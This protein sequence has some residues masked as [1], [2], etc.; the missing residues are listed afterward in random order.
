M[1]QWIGRRPVL[2]AAVL[3]TANLALAAPPQ[4]AANPAAALTDTQKEKFLLEGK[5][6]EAKTIDHG[7]TLPVRATLTDGTLKHDAQIQRVNKELT[8]FIRDGQGYPNHDSYKYNVAAYRLS[9]LIDLNT[10]PVTVPRKYLEKPGAFTWWAD[11]VMME[12]VARRKQ[13]LKAPDPEA[14]DR[15]LENS[16]VWDE[17]VINID[18]NL[19]NL[20][21][22]KDWQLVLI[23]HT[24]C[25]TAYP[26]I[27]NTDNLNRVSRKMLAKMKELNKQ[28]V[29][30]AV[31]DM[32]TAAEID[33]LL[34]RRDKIVVFFEKRAAE[35]GEDAV[36]FP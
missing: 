8:P 16:K 29:T 30:A 6:V 27:R 9:R 1:T 21:I 25:F 32:L 26:N 14:W 19:G 10:V 4:A 13:D 7:V 36:Y 22:T 11:N 33:A 15:E 24:R 2:A 12:E 18:R 17:L 31:G 20:L 5:I 35:K 28:N 34:Q 3:L 23:D